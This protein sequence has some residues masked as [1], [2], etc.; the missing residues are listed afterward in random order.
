MG[1]LAYKL[2]DKH[3]QALL[4]KYLQVQNPPRK[5]FGHH[6]THIFGVLDSR[7]EHRSAI[8]ELTGLYRDANFEVFTVKVNGKDTRPDGKPYHL[9]WSRSDGCTL[10][11][12]HSIDAIVPDNLVST[13]QI[14]MAC[15]L[16][17]FD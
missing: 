8:I 7:E 1:Y 6:V 5:V 13:T 9:T 17:Y 11:P 2:T 14:F 10:G 15:S 3:H 16:E 12:K 4:S